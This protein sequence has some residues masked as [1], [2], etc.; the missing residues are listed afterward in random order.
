RAITRCRCG[1]AGGRGPGRARRQPRPVGRDNGPSRRHARRIARRSAARL[2]ETQQ[3]P[4]GL[5]DQV[6]LD[7]ARA[8][9][10]HLA[11]VP[12][13]AVGE[14]VYRH[15][16]AE[17]AAG[18]ARGGDI[19]E[20]EP[21]GARLHLRLGSHPAQNLLGIGQQGKY[22]GGRRRNMRLA[23]NDEG[24]WHRCSPAHRVSHAPPISDRRVQGWLRE[25]ILQEKG[26]CFVQ[27]APRTWTGGAIHG[28]RSVNPEPSDVPRH[29]HLQRNGS[30]AHRMDTR[31]CRGR[32]SCLALSLAICSSICSRRLGRRG[33]FRDRLGARD[34]G[35]RNDPP[36]RHAGRDLQTHN[37]DRRERTLPLHA[38]PYL[39]R[40]GP[41]PDRPR[42]R[43]RQFVDPRDAG[44]VLSRHPLRR[45][46][47]R[48]SL[49]RAQVRRG[50]SRLQVP[51]SPLAVS[52]HAPDWI[53]R[54]LLL[55]PI[56]SSRR[57][58][59]RFTRC[60]RPVD[61]LWSMNSPVD[62]P[63]YS[64]TIGRS[65]PN[66]VSAREEAMATKTR[67]KAKRKKTTAR[68]TER[69]RKT[70]RKTRI[71]RKKAAKK[72]APR[73][74]PRTKPKSTAKVVVKPAPVS[75]RAQPEAGKP[76][77]RQPAQPT[78]AEQRIGVVTHYYGH[79]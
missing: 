75:Q 36:G 40:H 58:D 43:L 20:I 67:A 37:D 62:L 8:G 25:S 28:G 47:P 68:K 16:L 76:P 48:G 53:E 31:A 56:S 54:C 12:A 13:E 34:L 27:T 4:V 77:P 3:R 32:R 45:G 70:V 71:I 55:Q 19:E 50:L 22:R 18:A 30:P 52:K 1:R 21:A 2:S 73:R 44:A 15:H 29:G 72:A 65:F 74:A 5:L 57:G 10:H 23:A 17:G 64:A 46:R 41:W 39:S 9:R 35:D 69:R 33:Y 7:Q 14:A 42:D 79:L 38:Q 78:A 60:T 26:I 59:G 63:S 24:L 49:S 6:D 61:G 51:R 66:A 11:A